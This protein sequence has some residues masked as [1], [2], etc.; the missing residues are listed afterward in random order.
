MKAN[1]IRL[2]ALDPDDIAALDPWTDLDTPL[3]QGLGESMMSPTAFA[4]ERLGQTEE[5]AGPRLGACGLLDLHWPARR[6]RLGICLLDGRHWKA[7]IATEAVQLLLQ[8][9][10]DNLNLER[11][12]ISLTALDDPALRCLRSL[13]FMREATHRQAWFLGGVYHDV[14]E[15]SVLVNEWRHRYG[16][17]LLRQ[18]GYAPPARGGS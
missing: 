12:S 8:L 6:A 2:R 10:F 9:A 14:L 16:H 7:D 13:G 4:I 18:M 15:M 5:A 1:H 3:A 11:V 17:T